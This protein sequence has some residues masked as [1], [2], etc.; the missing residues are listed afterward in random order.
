MGAPSG[1]DARCSKCLRAGLARCIVRY[2]TEDAEPCTERLLLLNAYAALLPQAEEMQVLHAESAA[3][4][5]LT[6]A[7]QEAHVTMDATVRDMARARL[8]RRRQERLPPPASPPPRPA[9]APPGGQ[10]Q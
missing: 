4:P 5:A 9:S 3:I 2:S 8:E 10:Q 7:V 6:T 1:G